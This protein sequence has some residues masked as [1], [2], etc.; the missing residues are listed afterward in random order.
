MVEKKIKKRWITKNE[1]NYCD[2]SKMLFVFFLMGLYG[3]HQKG[4]CFDNSRTTSSTFCFAFCRQIATLF[5][6]PWPTMVLRCDMLP[7]PCEQT[8]RQGGLG[9]Y[10]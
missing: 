6:L 2:F 9:L 5:W 1:D 7:M 8:E 10:P 4:K 3:I